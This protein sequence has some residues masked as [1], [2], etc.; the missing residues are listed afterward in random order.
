MGGSDFL[1][2]LRICFD[3]RLPVIIY[4]EAGDFNKRGSLSKFN[5]VLNRTFET[6]RAFQIVVILDLPSFHVLDND[7]F[8]KNIPRL[9]IHL[10]GRNENYGNYQCYSLYRMMYI[11]DKMKKLVVKP[12]AY[13]LVEDNFRGHFKNLPTERR[14]LLD[15]VSIRGKLR[16][17][18]KSEIEAAGLFNYVGLATKVEMSIGWVK[19]QITLLNIKKIPF[20][21]TEED[22]LM[23]VCLNYFTSS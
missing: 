4:T 5:A 19:K 21:L 8:D 13:D 12:F 23:I 15:R 20:K 6:F 2:K 1:K 3:E 14:A 9:L 16:I 7:L 10:K 17:L 18:R 11:K 22:L